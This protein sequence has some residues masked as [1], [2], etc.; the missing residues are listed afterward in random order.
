MPDAYD[1]SESS[2]GEMALD[3]LVGRLGNIYGRFNLSPPTA[4]RDAARRWLNL[5]QHEIARWSRTICAS[6]TGF[7]SVG[8]VTAI[9]G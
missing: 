2:A 9:S 8:P 7:T 3:Q 1:G 5:S 4:S 6:T